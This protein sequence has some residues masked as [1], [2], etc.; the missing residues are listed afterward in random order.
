MAAK[1]K[2]KITHRS[3]GLVMGWG[4]VVVGGVDLFAGLVALGIGVGTVGGLVGGGQDGVVEEGGE[5][6]AGP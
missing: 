6:A 4:L 5:Q 2:T 1:H 3:S